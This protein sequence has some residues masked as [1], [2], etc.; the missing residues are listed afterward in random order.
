MRKWRYFPQN[1][2]VLTKKSIGN[3]V[4]FNKTHP[5]TGIGICSERLRNTS[6]VFGKLW[7]LPYHLWKS[8]HSQDKNLTPWTQ[9]KLA[10]IHV[11][12]NFFTELQ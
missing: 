9:K 8:W 1:L 3:D 4:V 5:R 11:F 10:G 7:T 12:Y 2:R 6:D